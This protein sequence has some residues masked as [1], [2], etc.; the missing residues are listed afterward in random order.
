VAQLI[1]LSVTEQAVAWLRQQV[2]D[3]IWPIGSKI[4]P[5]AELAQ[6]L[7]VARN[8]IREAVGALTHTGV[9]EI[10][11][12]AGTFVRSD[13]EVDAVFARRLLQA[14]Q[15]DTADLRRAI[16]VEATRLACTRRT[17]R[18]IKQLQAALQE[19]AEAM[20]VGTHLDYLNADYHFHRTVVRAAHSALLDE[21]FRCLASQVKAPIE[22]TAAKPTAAERHQ[23]HADVVAAI[24]ARDETAAI[25]AALVHLDVRL[26][27]GRTIP[28]SRS[29]AGV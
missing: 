24:A 5:E 2:S 3:G 20:L 23:A 22:E 1:R 12:G 15:K 14:D 9:L 8:T 29:G 13:T 4:P 17:D 11:R 28:H 27:K 18:D 7:G 19:R 10:R 16:E 26:K 25:R 21:L 6:E